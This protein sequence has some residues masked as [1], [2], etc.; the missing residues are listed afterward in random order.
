MPGTISMGS[1]NEFRRE[2]MGRSCRPRPMP[3]QKFSPKAAISLSKPISD[4]GGKAR[5]MVSVEAPGLMRAMAPSV[6]HGG[7]HVQER[8]LVV[9][10]DHARLQHHLLAV[11]HLDPRLLQGEEEG[12]LDEV[13]AERHAGHALL[14]QDGLDLLGRLVE[15]PRARRDGAP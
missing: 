4:A 12:R 7:G 3:W 8:E 1:S 6:H 15:E 9:A 13:D 2:M 11:A 10:L 14:L 5:A